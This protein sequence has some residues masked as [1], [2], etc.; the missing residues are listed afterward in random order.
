MKQFFY[1]TFLL[2]FGSVAFA[3]ETKFGIKV[4]EKTN[5]ATFSWTHRPLV[6]F[7]NSPND[8]NFRLQLKILSNNSDALTERDIV[9]L[10]DSDPEQ[11]S[12]LRKQLRPRGFTLILIG[13]DGQVKLRKPFPWKVRELTRIVDKMPIRL[14]EIEAQ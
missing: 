2:F 7:A 3:Q 1:V 14:Q 12:S 8:V 5:L 10:T 11:Q 13:K 6:I 9:V 4:T